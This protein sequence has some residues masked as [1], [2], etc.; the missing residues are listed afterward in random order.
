MSATSASVRPGW[1]GSERTSSHARTA[2]GHSRGF[3]AGHRRLAWNRHGIVNECLD[4]VGR[5][6]RLQFASG[7]RR[8]REQVIH[9]PGIVLG[10]NVDRSARERRPV[11]RGERPA[12]RRPA[13][14]TRQPRAKDRGLQSRRAAN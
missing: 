8:E 3:S 9:V 2:S 6:M 7:R 1:S 14:E 12:S 10:R 4:A 5:E 13:G 11:T